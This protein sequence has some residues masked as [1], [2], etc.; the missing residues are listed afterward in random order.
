MFHEFQWSFS[1]TSS[2]NLFVE[3]QN[4]SSVKCALAFKP[5]DA[6]VAQKNKENINS[7]RNTMAAAPGIILSRT[8]EEEN[9]QV[10]NS[11]GLDKEVKIES[12]SEA[13]L[14][15]D[16]SSDNSPSSLF[17]NRRSSIWKRLSQSSSMPSLRSLKKNQFDS[18]LSTD[19]V[20]SLSESNHLQDSAYSSDESRSAQSEFTETPTTPADS[21]SVFQI[22]ETVASGLAGIGIRDRN[23]ISIYSPSSRHLSPDSSTNKVFPRPG[24]NYAPSNSSPLSGN[25]NP[26][27]EIQ[28]VI[29]QTRPKLTRPA[30]S[31]QERPRRN[32]EIYRS[33]RL[34]IVPDK[35]AISS[36]DLMKILRGPSSYPLE[37][38]PRS[39]RNSTI[40]Y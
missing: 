5:V 12:L 16:G 27:A 24:M 10:G 23:S 15:T 19:K 34:N 32:R 18:D 31:S 20:E 6:P 21:V 4:I 9:N 28:E 1:K 3:P 39:N 40:F 7:I 35:S 13:D 14:N 30:S 2:K 33:G 25:V 22:N 38:I 26:A 8:S 11:S 29:A 37:C 17:D 36:E